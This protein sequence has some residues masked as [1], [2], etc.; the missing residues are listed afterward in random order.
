M[1]PTWGFKKEGRICC[2]GYTFY[3]NRWAEKKGENIKPQNGENFGT[4][5]R[6]IFVLAWPR[7]PGLPAAHGGP[8]ESVVSGEVGS[9]RPPI[10]RP[11]IAPGRAAAAG[12]AS[13]GPSESVP[14]FSGEVGSSRPPIM[15][16]GIAPRPP[17]L[18]AAHGGP[19]ESV[20]SGEVGRSRPP[21]MRPGIAPGRAASAEDVS[22]T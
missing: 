2:F 16:P 8:S 1:Y 20:V 22:C 19:S 3:P 17:G 7:P 6:K 21:I 12:V 18:P 15:R 14:G 5:T 9:S 4:K 10:L 13:C 11:G